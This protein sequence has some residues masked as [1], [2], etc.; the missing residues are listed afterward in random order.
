MNVKKNKADFRL[1]DLLSSIIYVIL[2]LLLVTAVV[3]VNNLFNSP[4]IG[5]VLVMLGKWRVFSVKARFWWAN[6][7]SNSVDFLVGVSYVFLI[8]HLSSSGLL[9][10][11]LLAGL[12]L[13][14]LLLIK[15]GNSPKSIMA[16]GIIAIFASNVVLSLFCY[17]WPVWGFLPLEMIIGYSVMNH[18]LSNGDFEA[19]CTKLI[20]GIWALVMMELA[21]ISWH[22]LVGYD[23]FGLIKIS[24][25]AIISAL[26]TFLSYKVLQSTIADKKISQKVLQADLL[27]SIGLVCLIVLIMLI[28][29]MKPVMV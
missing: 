15:P 3:F 20:S 16:Q 13:F 26:T 25:F 6:I 29:F 21:W 5:V 28:F 12:Y 24:Q 9:Y 8:Y 14:W 19:R 11:A 17:K 1:P 10:Q 18:F 7:V 23:L 2:N 4:Y 27:I 22:W